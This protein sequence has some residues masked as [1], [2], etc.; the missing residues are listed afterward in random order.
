MFSKKI[1]KGDFRTVL[2]DEL[3][4][5]G[6]TIRELAE[7]ADIPVA[8]LYKSSSGNVD[9]RLSTMKKIVGVLEPE[10]PSFIAVIA[11][12]FLLDEMEGHEIT[13]R[14]RIYKIRGYTANSIEECIIACRHGRKRRSGRNYLCANTCVDGREDRRCA[15]S[16]HETES[17]NRSRCTGRHRTE[18]MIGVPLEKKYKSDIPGL[19]RELPRGI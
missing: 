3:R 13:I 8:T 10:L 1:F 14:G 2:E 11:A 15:G 6:M 4:R 17:H 7:Q 19:F 12:K 9:I 5:R 18:N 16:H